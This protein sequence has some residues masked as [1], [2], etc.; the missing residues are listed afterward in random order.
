VL[1]VAFVSL[2]VATHLNFARA[3]PGPFVFEQG[4]YLF[5]A[6]AAVAV[7]GVGACYAFGR[8]WAP[9]LATAAV[10]G[11][12]VFSGLCQLFVFTTYYT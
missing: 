5:P 11:M 7:G 6:A 4:R 12:M 9:V 3:E 10:T 8:R 2:A 1:A